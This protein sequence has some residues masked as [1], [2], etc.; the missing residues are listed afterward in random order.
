MRSFTIRAESVGVRRAIIRQILD[1]VIAEVRS[2]QPN[3]PV[4]MI[5]AYLSEQGG[6]A[7]LQGPAE[8]IPKPMRREVLLEAVQRLLPPK[9][10][11]RRKS[12]STVWHVSSRCTE[13][14]TEKFEEQV[15]SSPPA[16]GEFCNECAVKQ[17]K[18]DSC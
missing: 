10:V 18:N 11:Y 8:F 6:K 14:P 13:W 4:I 15:F 2:I 7:I 9:S 1:E 5:T 3:L 17:K 16:S 12:G